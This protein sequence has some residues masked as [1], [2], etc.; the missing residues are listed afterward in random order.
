MLYYLLGTK[1]ELSE[2]DLPVGFE[3]GVFTNAKA[4]GSYHVNYVYR[5]TTDDEIELGYDI[6][7]IEDFDKP[8]RN[9]NRFDAFIKFLKTQINDDNP[10]FLTRQVKT[11]DTMRDSEHNIIYSEEKIV[12][13]EHCFS[14]NSFRFEDNILYVFQ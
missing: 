5:L 13:S 4:F 1:Q 12:L 3:L 10:I 6:R 9:K 2:N 7:N 11:N 14:E 8:N